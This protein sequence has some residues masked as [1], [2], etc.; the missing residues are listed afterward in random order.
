MPCP[1]PSWLHR[2]D[3]G[4]PE[5]LCKTLSSTH[6]GPHPEGWGLGSSTCSPLQ[7]PW[8]SP[9]PL[10]ARPAPDPL[11]AGRKQAHEAAWLLRRP[12][13][14]ASRGESAAGGRACAPTVGRSPHGLCRPGLPRPC[15]PVPRPPA[16]AR[17]NA[18]GSW[19]FGPNALLGPAQGELGAG[20]SSLQAAAALASW[21]VVQAKASQQEGLPGGTH[22]FPVATPPKQAP[23]PRPPPSSS[24]TEPVAASSSGVT[25]GHCG[26]ACPQ[27]PHSWASS[28]PPP[29]RTAHTLTCPQ[30]QPRHAGQAGLPALPWGEEGWPQAWLSPGGSRGLSALSSGSGRGWGRGPAWTRTGRPLGSTLCAGQHPSQGCPRTPRW[31]WTRTDLGT[32]THPRAQGR[33]RGAAASRGPEGREESPEE[34][35]C[36]LGLC[37]A[38]S[39]LALEH[40]P[41]RGCRT[42]PEPPPRAQPGQ[43]PLCPPRPQPQSSLRLVPSPRQL[44]RQPCLA[45][46]SSAWGS[47][48]GR[49]WA[50][51][52]TPARTWA[53]GS[54]RPT[55]GLPPSAGRPGCLGQPA[56]DGGAG[57]VWHWGGLPCRACPEVPA[58]SVSGDFLQSPRQH[59]GPPTGAGGPSPPLSP[60]V[61]P[62]RCWPAGR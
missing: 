16:G 14:T 57:Q 7:G 26:Q 30:C 52:M 56:G 21:P 1:A 54:Q 59:Q 42:R 38:P 17:V 5:W 22:W 39:C 58:H 11:P 37:G 23:P 62:G 33:N 34:E 41:L 6:Q 29:P 49:P 40:W 45:A 18:Q 20:S 43:S 28:L 13:W 53:L 47:A 19:T 27:R 9:G 36:F 4:T 46:G 50:A 48:P 35:G 55:P 3:R 60:A 24:S 10:T 15:P 2:A 25:Q 8:A 32:L 31:C 12:A 44:A 51:P 61:G